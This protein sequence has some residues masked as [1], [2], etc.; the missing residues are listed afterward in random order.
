MRIPYVI[1]NR[2]AKLADVLNHLLGHFQSRWLD[3]ASADFTI[4]RGLGVRSQS[5]ILLALQW[6]GALGRGGGE[7]GAQ[8]GGMGEIRPRKAE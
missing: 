6:V 1:D 2:D 7:E 8:D 5:S 3:I 4:R